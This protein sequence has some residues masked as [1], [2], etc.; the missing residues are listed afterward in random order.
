[1]LKGQFIGRVNLL[2][3]NCC[4]AMRAHILI[5]G[6]VQGVGFRYFVADKA[7]ELGLTGWVKN[8]KD[9]NVEAEFQSSEGTVARDLAGK[10]SSYEIYTKKPL[11]EKDKIKVE[12]MI[13]LCKQGS[14]MS[15]V[16]N[17]EVKWEEEDDDL[18]T[19]FEIR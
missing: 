7:I 1:M 4:K 14:S 6:M 12:E 15:A 17:V 8:K 18:L 16:N 13:E 11:M 9:G 3:V 5:S 19:S 10:Q 2:N